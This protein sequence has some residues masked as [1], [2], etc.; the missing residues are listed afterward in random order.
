M[1]W[2]EWLEQRRVLLVTG[3]S[4]IG[5]MALAVCARRN[6]VSFDSFWH[7]KMGEDWIRNGLSPWVDHYS[8]T[9]AGQDISSP[10]VLFQALLYW[11]VEQFG[12]TPGYE[13]LKFVCFA[14]TLV[15]VLLYLR[16]VRAHVF[17]YLLVVPM[18]TALIE[19]RVAVRP[20][21]VSYA[22]MVAALMLY[23]RANGKV[24][25]S[26]VIPIAL[27]MW[28]WSNY[29]NP[30]IGYVI[31]FGLFVDAAVGQIASR[32]QPSAWIRW[33]GWGLLVLGVGF[34]RPGF[35]HPLYDMLLFDPEWR[36]L[37]QEYTSP[38]LFYKGVEAIYALIAI[39]VVALFLSVRHRRI[40][41]LAIIAVLVYGASTMARLVTPAGIVITCLFAHL[42]SEV[43]WK[44]WLERRGTTIQYSTGVIVVALIAL[45][46]WTSVSL[47]R[48]YMAEN[49]V[50]GVRFP[51]DVVR[52][53]KDNGRS[54]RI[55]NQYQA[56][57]YLI[58]HTFPD[59]KVY[60][61]GRTDILYPVD[62]Y[63]RLKQAEISP[64]VFREEVDKYDITLAVLE[65]EPAH[66]F[67]MHEVGGFYLDFVGA[68]YSLFVTENPMLPAFGHL[69]GRPAC[70]SE[71][72]AADLQGEQANAIM[73]L[74]SDSALW[75]FLRAVM[76]YLGADDQLNV[77]MEIA[78]SNAQPDLVLRFASF[79]AMDLGDN[80]L[81]IRLLSRVSDKQL[82]DH[83]AAALNMIRMRDFD[84]AETTL[85]IASETPW[86]YLELPDFVIMNGLLETLKSE[87]P[88]TL[89]SD[90]FVENIERQ[91]QV[92]GL[93]TKDF[94][95]TTELFCAGDGWELGNK[96]LQR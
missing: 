51:G 13:L 6:I 45:P 16:Q 92:A 53:M 49:R 96:A 78:R 12:H 67:L 28:F 41:Y 63:T 29:H 32:A 3:I 31:F 61:D 77:L 42:V 18:V 76:N 19:L 46:L 40:G 4:V 83:L 33:L 50:S 57:G 30:I 7:L 89:V 65:N 15:L 44:S 47:A 17:V 54:G 26:T 69:L 34:L 8:F 38:V 84:N 55:F 25:A 2:F 24:K 56:G 79:R 37:I 74:L 93:T 66:Y 88:L 64:R 36:V 85:R 5:A 39:T 91:V 82:K 71:E 9:F 59:S 52:H 73:Y 1:N 10:P 27:L 60:I 80:A 72:L 75:P 43:D 23:Q 95:I 94:E 48:E 14:L 20:E 68:G 21:L 58:Y 81:A 11:F 35:S 90:D 87:R 70:W 62:H 22:L 86:P